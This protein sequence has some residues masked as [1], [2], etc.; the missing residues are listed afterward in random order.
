MSD[1]AVSLT[2]FTSKEAEYCPGNWIAIC[3]NQGCDFSTRTFPASGIE[4]AKKI[5]LERHS[6]TSNPNDFQHSR[7]C[8]APKII[9]GRVPDE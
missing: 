3:G 5:A 6:R 2:P 7:H 1:K 9:A 4:E 8:Y